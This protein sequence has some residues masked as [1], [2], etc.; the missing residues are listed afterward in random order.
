MPEL[1][2]AALMFPALFIL[3]FLGMPVSLSLISVSAVVSMLLFRTMISGMICVF[4]FWSWSLLGVSLLH[5][6]SFFLGGGG[7]FILLLFMFD[8][9]EESPLGTN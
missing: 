7:K 5:K 9:L 3:I 4:P 1:P 8:M 6:R 2:Y